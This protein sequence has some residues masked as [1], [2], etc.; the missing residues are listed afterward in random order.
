M[1]P[2]FSINMQKSAVYIHPF[3]EKAPFSPYNIDIL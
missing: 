2:A 1:F 3:L